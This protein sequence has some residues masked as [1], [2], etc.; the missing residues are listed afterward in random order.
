M[1]GPIVPPPPGLFSITNGWPSCR[2][3]WSSTT[4]ATVSLAFP[5]VNGLMTCIG[6][7]GQASPSAAA[8]AATSATPAMA[9]HNHD[10]TSFEPRWDGW[11]ARRAVPRYAIHAI[12]SD[13]NAGARIITKASKDAT[14]F[15]SV[16]ELLSRYRRKDLSPVEMVDAVLDQVDRANGVVNAYCWLDREGA[17]RSA[18][19]AEA[20]WMAG[21]PRG[22]IDGVPVGIK[23]NILV[24]GMPAR[25]GSR[26][27][28][29]ELSTHDAPAVARLR[30]Q[31]AILIGKTTM[32]EFGWKAVTDSPLTG[33]TRN[34]WDTRKTPGGSSG[35][36]VA[37]V[38]LGMGNIHLGTD[39]GGSI[40]IP[41]AFGGSYGIKPTRARVPAWPAS[42][43]GT[44]AHAGC[45]TRSV[46]DA[47]L[48]LTIM[49]AP[50]RRDV[51]AWTSPA[52]DFATGL[53]DGVAG[54]RVAYSPRLGYAERV[55]GEVETAVSAAVRVFEEHGA[56]V[57]EADPELDGDPIAAWNTLWWPAFAM[58][59][60]S[61]GER[62]RDVADPG[63]VAAAARGLETTAMDHIR[64]QLKRAE[65]HAVFARFFQRYDLLLTP[66]MPLPA[67]EAGR[68]MPPS[69]D[70]GEAWTNWSP[71]TCPFNLT[72][73]PAASIPCG[74]TRG[75]LP[76]GLQIVGAIGAD[77]LVLRASRAFEAAKPFCALKDPCTY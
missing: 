45:L 77:A 53:D 18:R 36:A 16:A 35:G 20:R 54:M 32:P 37:A 13:A 67:F 72:Q 73:Q 43:L 14:A 66:T 55:E 57:D 29:D 28:S 46:A 68:L 17:R 24:A 31:G 8:A 12:R 65:L 34:P 52:P 15:L 71:F 51:Y 23:D 6:R 9:L 50:D 3:T 5:A 30:E 61:Y 2:E 38:V 56:H 47:A 7:V 22:L 27:T 58:L 19:D 1:A 39:G 70:W 75:G 44:L 62:V 11:V 59:L 69:G 4:R 48:A 10:V 33:V 42:P 21:A 60:Q 76:I 63:L 74:M 26:L 49:A 41:A 25:F 40:R 64:A